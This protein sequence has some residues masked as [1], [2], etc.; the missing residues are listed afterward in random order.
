MA[1]YWAPDFPNI[2]GICHITGS[3][4]ELTE[5]LCSYLVAHCPDTG[6]M[7]GLQAQVR[8]LL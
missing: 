4:L 2:E 7:I 8:L 1:T 5:V 6:F 3:G